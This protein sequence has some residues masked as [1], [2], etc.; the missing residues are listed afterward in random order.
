MTQPAVAPASTRAPATAVSE[1][2]RPHRLTSLHHQLLDIDHG[3]TYIDARPA[4]TLR[5]LLQMASIAAAARAL[6]SLRECPALDLTA[7][8]CRVAVA[9][10]AK[11]FGS[12]FAAISFR[13]RALRMTPARNASVFRMLSARKVRT[14]GSTAAS[15]AA[16]PME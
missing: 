15:V 12:Q 1:L 4:G 2:A 8:V 11:A 9:M 6:S 3:D 7:R 13:S 14:A 5:Y 10:P 16:V